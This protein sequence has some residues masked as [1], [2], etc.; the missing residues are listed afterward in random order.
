MLSDAEEKQLTDKAVKMWLG[1]LHD[2]AYDVENILDEFAMEAL[3]RKW[4]VEHHQSSS[5]N[6]KVQNLFIPAC[7]TV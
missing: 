3:A 5:S 6:S 4:K 7:F 2:L 1:D